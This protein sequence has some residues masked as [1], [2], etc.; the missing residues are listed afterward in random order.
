MDQVLVYLRGLHDD[1]GLSGDRG[2]FYRR[3][4]AEQIALAFAIDGVNHNNVDI[5]VE[6]AIQLERKTRQILTNCALNPGSVPPFDVSED[7]MDILSRIA[8]IF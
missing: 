7:I 4:L 2:D 3:K 5:I 1:V 6:T 8:E